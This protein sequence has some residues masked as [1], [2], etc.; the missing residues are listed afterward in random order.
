ME[1]NTQVNPTNRTTFYSHKYRSILLPHYHSNI[2]AIVEAADH[3]VKGTPGAIP[4]TDPPGDFSG[5]TIGPN[6]IRKVVEFLNVHFKG[7]EDKIKCRMLCKFFC[8]VRGK[9]L[10]SVI[11]GR[12]GSDTNKDKMQA[13]L[14]LKKYIETRR[15]ALETSLREIQIDSVI[16]PTSSPRR[17]YRVI[18]SEAAN[19]FFIIIRKIWSEF[20]LINAK[21]KRYNGLPGQGPGVGI[22]L[23]EFFPRRPDIT[24]EL[25]DGLIQQDIT[26]IQGFFQRFQTGGSKK[27]KGGSSEQ[28]LTFKGYL[29][30]WYEMTNSYLKHPMFDSIIES[31]TEALEKSRIALYN[32]LYEQIGPIAGERFI[33]QIIRLFM[34]AQ[35]LNA[36][37]CRL[38]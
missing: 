26:S 22:T 2:R 4:S 37:P 11:M 19:K 38:I 33:K 7:D 31:G 17:P 9:D 15:I 5:K 18:R 8:C 6:R 1:I 12:M 25:I 32:H 35:F 30:K 13:Y 3:F 20:D 23:S 14:E 24:K 16:E 36:Q 27:Q 21:I 29:D 28:I 10:I 34:F